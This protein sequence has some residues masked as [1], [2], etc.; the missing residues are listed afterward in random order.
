METKIKILSALLIPF[1]FLCAGVYNIG[2]WTTFN[3]NI[4]PYLNFT[5]IITSSIIPV[6]QSLATTIG[7]YLFSLLSGY[8]FDLIVLRKPAKELKTN[9]SISVASLSGKGKLNSFWLKSSSIFKFISIVGYALL[10]EHFL[11]L[12]TKTGT[13]YLAYLILPVIFLF[14]AKLLVKQ[15]L[16]LDG[17]YL[18]AILL[19]VSLLPSLSYISGRSKGI[20]IFENTEFEYSTKLLNKKPL[21]FLGKAGD[22]YILNS[23]D[24]S[25]KYFYSTTEIKTLILSHFKKQTEQTN[26]LPKPF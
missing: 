9:E 5:D 8:H 15:N 25:E 3:I 11:N 10:I 19:F 7:T 17:G 4:F 22:Y 14:L 23:V 2:Y 16:K 1:C 20:A 24:N 26:T 12:K 18:F 21:K 13:V 6:I